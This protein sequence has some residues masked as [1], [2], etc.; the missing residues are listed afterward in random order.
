MNSRVGRRSVTRSQ[1]KRDGSVFAGWRPRTGCAVAKPPRSGLLR[2]AGEAPRGL[3]IG[4]RSACLPILETILTRAQDA[5]QPGP[6]Q[7]GSFACRLRRVSGDGRLSSAPGIGCDEQRLG[8]PGA[9]TT[10]SASTDRWLGATLQVNSRRRLE[11]Q[12]SEALGRSPSRAARTPARRRRERRPACAL[13]C[14][15][16][17]R[18]RAW[19][20]Y[21]VP[22]VAGG[23]P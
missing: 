7:A 3:G 18:R 6:G 16:R 21:Q 22:G 4:G 1:R 17:R 20:A 11:P 8:N 23:S 19:A 12:G 13:T 10:N 14:A 15:R 2:G 9:A 5:G